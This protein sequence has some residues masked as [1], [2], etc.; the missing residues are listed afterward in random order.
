MRP[1]SSWRA[2]SGI[3]SP[4]VL[5]AAGLER[6]ALVGHSMGS[7]LVLEAAARHPDKVRALVMIGTAVPMAVTD[8]LLNN[9]RANDH[10]AIDMLTIWGYS[11]SKQLGGNETPGM[12]MVGGTMRLLERS[13]PGILYNDLHASHEYHHGLD[14]AKQLR[15]PTMLILGEEDMLTPPK[16][17]KV[18]ADA[19]PESRI[20][21]LKGGGHSMMSEQPD[22]VLDALIEIV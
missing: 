13:A 3:A 11:R 14:S 12:W 19:I 2:P 18:I 7:L 20:V 10:M 8:A 22:A 17:A 21:L 9:A 16:R 6:A 1:E 5:Q 4:N 15:C